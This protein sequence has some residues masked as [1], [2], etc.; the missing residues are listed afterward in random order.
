MKLKQKLLALSVVAALAGTAQAATETGTVTLTGTV[1]VGCTITSPTADF[2]AQ[3]PTNTPSSI[4]SV[5]IDI[6]CGSGTPWSLSAP[7]GN[8][9]MVGAA[10]NLSKLQSS[11]T[12][13]S[14]AAPLTGT[15][16]GAVQSTPVDVVLYG[17]AMNSGL[18]AGTGAISGTI[19][20]TLTY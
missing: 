2:G 3:V 20:L 8:T 7:V 4:K 9:T 13:I 19:P 15:G 11:G 16:T 14:A 18:I 1:I 5:N 6:K 12:V 17:T 10:T